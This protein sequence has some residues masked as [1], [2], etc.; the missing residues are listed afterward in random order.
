MA[1]DA[2]TDCGRGRKG[3]ENDLASAA[4][5]GKGDEDVDGLV[6]TVALAWDGVD[7]S[8]AGVAGEDMCRSFIGGIGGEGVRGGGG[9]PSDVSQASRAAFSS[10][11]A[12]GSNSLSTSFETCAVGSGVGGALSLGPANAGSSNNDGSRG[13]RGFGRSS[14]LVESFL[15]G[16]RESFHGLADNGTSGVVNGAGG[17]ADAVDCA[18][19]VIAIQRVFR[20]QCRRNIIQRAT[21][22]VSY[23]KK[24]RKR[25]IGNVK[26]RIWTPVAAARGRRVLSSRSLIR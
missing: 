25:S 24:R 18:S 6:V 19:S 4:S 22:K 26:R 16:G 9:C 15:E 10:R 17:A 2:S 1:D 20:E 14:S 7:G 5:D 12:R 3:N 8:R 11:L 13:A 21:S 23:R